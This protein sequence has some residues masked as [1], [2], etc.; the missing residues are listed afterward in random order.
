MVIE[1][2]AHVFT[3]GKRARRFGELRG[4]VRKMGRRV[5]GYRVV[6]SRFPDG[7]TCWKIGVEVG[8]LRKMSRSVEGYRVGR[9]VGYLSSRVIIFTC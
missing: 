4:G 6:R 8:G 7:K 1:Q 3:R 9:S 5:E 2:S